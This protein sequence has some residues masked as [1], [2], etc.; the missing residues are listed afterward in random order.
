MYTV[1]FYTLV[2][3]LALSVLVTLMYEEFRAVRYYLLDA[4]TGFRR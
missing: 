2:A 4:L 3:V 1:M